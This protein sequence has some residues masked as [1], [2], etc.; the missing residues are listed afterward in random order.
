MVHLQNQQP[1]GHQLDCLET[2]STF[3]Q[4]CNHYHETNNDSKQHWPL[5]E[6]NVLLTVDSFSC[7]ILSCIASGQLQT[8][9][10]T[11][12]PFD[13]ALRLAVT[14]QNT[15]HKKCA[16][17]LRVRKI[18]KLRNCFGWNCVCH[19]YKLPTRNY[20]TEVEHEL[21]FLTTERLNCML[22]C[23]SKSCYHTNVSY[24]NRRA[25]VFNAAAGQD[26]G[27]P[28]FVGQVM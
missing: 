1:S 4:C 8:N 24:H 26:A 18:A 16:W 28:V 21:T 9:F 3:S 25:R 5:I 20:N 23:K 2:A 22:S 15:E 11:V 10:H 27:G 6:A 17:V 14:L 12:K 7:C 13:T 19:V